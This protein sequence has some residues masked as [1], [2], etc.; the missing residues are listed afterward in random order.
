MA[1]LGDKTEFAASTILRQARCFHNCWLGTLTEADVHVTVSFEANHCA[2][3]IVTNTAHGAQRARMVFAIPVRKMLPPI[4]S[5][6]LLHKRPEGGGNGLLW[7]S[8]AV[9]QFWVPRKS[10]TG[11]HAL[12]VGHAHHLRPLVQASQGTCA[13]RLSSGPCDALNI[14]K[15]PIFVQHQSQLREYSGLRGNQVERG[16]QCAQHRDLAHVV[17]IVVVGSMRIGDERSQR[18]LPVESPLRSP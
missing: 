12:R 2:N 11:L 4:S 18:L 16:Q 10:Y 1:M 3:A 14:G 5:G 8:H 7:E 17:P 9:P 13:H 6:V 15:Q